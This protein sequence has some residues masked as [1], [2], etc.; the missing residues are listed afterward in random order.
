MDRLADYWI[1]EGEHFSK[2]NCS[3]QN[4]HFLTSEVIVLA[5]K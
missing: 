3:G 1:A 2:M 4:F 5:S